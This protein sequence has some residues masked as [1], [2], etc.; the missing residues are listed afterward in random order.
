MGAAVEGQVAVD[1]VGNDDDTVAL[2]DFSQL[3]QG[4][5]V[6]EEADGVVR[7]AQDQGLRLRVEQLL[8]PLEIHPVAAVLEKERVVHGHPAEAL[9]IQ[10]EMVIHRRLDD[11]LVARLRKGEIG[12]VDGRD[13]AGGIADQLLVRRVAM[14]L[15][16]PGGDGLHERFRRGRIAQDIPVQPLLQ[17]R[18]DIRVRPEIHVGDPHRNLPVRGPSILD[19]PGARPVDDFIKTPAFRGLAARGAGR[20]RGPDRAGRHQRRRAGGRHALQKCPSFHRNKDTSFQR[21]KK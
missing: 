15:P 8:Q 4:F 20:Q 3:H 11:D 5:P 21:K 13:D 2:A 19:A 10:A 18:A 14:G 12:L 17:R 9:D 16:L 1:F 7:I 6:P